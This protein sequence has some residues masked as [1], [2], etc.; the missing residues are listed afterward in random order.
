[1]LGEKRVIAPGNDVD[2]RIANSNDVVGGLAHGILIFSLVKIYISKDS[3]A[4]P[5]G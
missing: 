5:F 3:Y 1:M 4:A 2:Y